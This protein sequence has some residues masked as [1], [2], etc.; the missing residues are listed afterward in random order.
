MAANGTIE[1]QAR[2]LADD[3]RRAEPDIRKIYWF[4]HEEEVRLVELTDLIPAADEEMVQPF[5]FQASPED[6]LPAPSG[7]AMIRPEEFGKL[8][9]PEDWG[10]WAQAVEL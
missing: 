10:D 5:Y 2:F 7:I 9:L 4:P 3:N 1:R 6:N 8:K